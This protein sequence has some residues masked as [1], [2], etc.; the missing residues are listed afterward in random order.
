MIVSKTLNLEPVDMEG[1]ADPIQVQRL[2]KKVFGEFFQVFWYLFEVIYC[3]EGTCQM[4]GWSEF[5]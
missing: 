1:Y 2:P 3:F 4:F 5:V